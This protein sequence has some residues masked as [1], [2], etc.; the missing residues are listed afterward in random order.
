[1]R[2][3]VCLLLVLCLIPLVA[4]ADTVMTVY[5]S[6]SKPGKTGPVTVSYY[7]EQFDEWAPGGHTT[8][9]PRCPEGWV[10]D[11]IT[12]GNQRY[13]GVS[14]ITLAHDDYTSDSTLIGVSVKRAPAEPVVEPTEPT[15]EDPSNN[16]P[17]GDNPTGS[18]PSGNDPSGDYPAGNDPT[19]NDPSGDDPAGN[20]PAGDESGNENQNNQPGNDDT[21]NLPDDITNGDNQSGNDPSEDENTPSGD[22]I[23]SGTNND[24]P[25]GGN[26]DEDNPG[27]S[28]EDTDNSEENW[29]DMPIYVKDMEIAGKN[30]ALTI[31]GN[32][33]TVKWAPNETSTFTSTSPEGYI[34]QYGRIGSQ[35]YNSKSITISHNDFTYTGSELIVE[36]L[37]KKAPAVV[38]PEEPDNNETVIPQMGVCVDDYLIVNESLLGDST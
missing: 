35:L 21:N 24:N 8:I 13:D 22:D 2:K 38:E 29:P 12:I 15:N 37:Y 25:S 26:L 19:G 32:R 3:I 6:V 9:T 18:D 7:S 33:T 36:F 27:G 34:F 20:D 31:T 11:F 17:S 30:S 1:M 5:V 10:V 28:S 4:F 23:A 16:D 14:S